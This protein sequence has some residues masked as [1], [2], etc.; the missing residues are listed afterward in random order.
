MT[1]HHTGN[2]SALRIVLIMAAAAAIIVAAF[3]AV[4]L[5]AIATYNQAT[6]SLSE[7]IK[8]FQ[9]PSADLDMLKT[10]QQQTNEQFTD[11]GALRLF[12]LPSVKRPVEANAEV[13]DTLTQRIN[14][15]LDEQTK[16]KAANSGGSASGSSTPRNS[17]QQSLTDEQRKQ[18][19]E[20]LQSNE[21][22]SKA[23]NGT[24]DAQRS[25]NTDGTV[26]PW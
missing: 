12:L 5:S 13:S 8:H 18:V 16:S 22:S 4:N 15:A 24:D 20:L 11:A 17:Q 7:N 25:G 6:Q 1:E 19:E 21:Q 2:R 26:K 23:S 9:S 10:R 3:C 14:A